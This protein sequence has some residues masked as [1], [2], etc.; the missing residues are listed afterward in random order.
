MKLMAIDP[1]LKGGVAMFDETGI[2][3]KTWRMPLLKLQYGGRGKQHRLIAL[4]WLSQIIVDYRVDTIVLEVPSA[5]PGQSSVSTA[6]SFTNWGLLLSLASVR[7]Y[8]RPAIALH[9]VYPAMWK[10]HY[11]LDRD[12][13]RAI[14]RARDLLG[15]PLTDKSTD[16]EAE[17]AL[18][19]HYWRT[20]GSE[21]ERANLEL[22]K[23]RPKR[24][25][26]KASAPKRRAARP[27]A[28]SPAPPSPA[29][30]PART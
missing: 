2:L 15:L 20:G 5:M 24:R 21:R 1:G 12:K 9:C 25:K 23:S 30:A 6:T 13:T 27:R 14:K 17:A 19:G 4:S 16:G 22:Q 3:M 11:G 10:K 29:A 18:I 8:S 7:D 28:S 26:K